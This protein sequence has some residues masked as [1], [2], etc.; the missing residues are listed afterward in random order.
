[1]QYIETT[2][3]MTMTAAGGATPTVRVWLDPSGEPFRDIN[4]SVSSSGG[5][6]PAGGVTWSVYYGGAF[7]GPL[8]VDT[9]THTGGILQ[10]T[11]LFAGAAEVATVIH[12][13]TDIFPSNLRQRNLH[14]ETAHTLRGYGGFPIVLELTNNAA[15]AV[16][17]IASLVARTVS[18]P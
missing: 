15:V 10:A 2:K 13:D 17:L 1:M 6:L 16:T 14:V 4:I 9:S 12:T 8:Y 3:E 11:N 18:I 7:T 5:A